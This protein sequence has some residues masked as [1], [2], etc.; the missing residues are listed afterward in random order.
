MNPILGKRII[1]IV[2][3]GA[4]GLI[5]GTALYGILSPMHGHYLRRNILNMMPQ[6]GDFAYT[7]AADRKTV[8]VGDL[9]VVAR[10]DCT[11]DEKRAGYVLACGDDAVFVMK[12]APDLQLPAMVK[13]I[14]RSKDFSSEYD[15]VMYVLS[16]SYG[17]YSFRNLLEFSRVDDL[18]R[19]KYALCAANRAVYYKKFGDYSVIEYR[20]DN[21]RMFDVY[22]KDR[23]DTL[24]YK[25]KTDAQNSDLINRLVSTLEFTAP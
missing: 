12:K 21:R 3:I 4:V 9:K 16:R 19:L 8:V 11:V 6:Q 22:R 24:V 25:K 14:D 20:H 18:L 10:N 7:D 23:K 17:D 1:V 2:L 5:V 13:T 15:A